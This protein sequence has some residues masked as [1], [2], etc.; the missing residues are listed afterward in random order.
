MPRKQKRQSKL[1]KT[2]WKKNVKK[3]TRSFNKII[4]WS[5]V[6]FFSTA[7]Y[8]LYDLPD[9]EKVKPIDTKP[10]I[11]ILANDGSLIARYGGKQGDIVGIRDIPQHLIEAVLSVEDRRFYKHFGIDLRGLARAMWVNLKSRRWVQGGS[12]I[13]QQLTKNLFL[14]PDKTIKRKVQEVLMA[15]QI[16]HKFNKNEILTAYLNRVYF[17]SGA[18]G[19]DAASKTYFNK[20][21]SEI[22]L[23]ESAVLAGLL[24][25]PS[26]YS[27]ASNPE[28][29]KDRAESVIK[30]MEDAGYIDAATKAEEIKNVKI[31]E[32]SKVAGN[33]K[34][35][36]ADWVINQIDSFVTTTDGDIVVRTTLDPNLQTLAEAKQKEFFSK[37]S[38]KSSVSQVALITEGYDGAILSM[39]GGVNYKQ[40]QFNRATQAMRQTGS[41]F[42]PFIYLAALESGF[43]TDNL[44][45]DAPI[46][47]GDY[48]PK[49]YKDK[50]FG[51]VSFSDALV[52]S[53]NTATVRLLKQIGFSGLKDVIKRLGINS[54]INEDLSAALGTSE[55]SL[56]EMTNAYSIIANG[57]KAVWPY[58]VAAIQD[59]NGNVLYQRQEYNHQ[60]LFMK[61]DIKALNSML[62]K[63]VLEGTGKAAQLPGELVAGKTGTTQDYRDAWFV[64][65][66]DKF[67]TGIWMGNDDNKTMHNVTGGGAPAQLWQRYMREAVKVDVPKFRPI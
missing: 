29:A 31:P 26:R 52:K 25:A 17:G 30:I 47:E 49:N 39:L 21:A 14:T 42:K 38:E 10:S 46:V 32:V 23:W 51:N 41:A 24:K 54:N 44:L 66:S 59:G 27:P 64:G 16:E 57:G 65:Y 12:T 53:M 15:L 19:V 48:H 62:V 6:I 8:F 60:R 56:L 18:Y 58:A 55:V 11:T 34:R 13:T 9:I 20:P 63:V 2:S 37:V 40:S 5:F 33:S 7:V 28:L 67:I 3:T 61:K 50:Y 1:K 35:Y 22:T 43:T 45:E 4:L 36:F